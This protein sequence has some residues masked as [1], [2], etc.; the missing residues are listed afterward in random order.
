MPGNI[1]D[2]AATSS[3]K[4]ENIFDAAATSS[5]KS[6]NMFDDVAGSVKSVA[7]KA[8]HVAGDVLDFQRAK[9]QEMIFHGGSSDE[10]RRRL[11][12]KIGIEHDYEDPKFLGVQVPEWATHLGRG[13]TDTALDTVTDPLTYETM[14]GSLIAKGAKGLAGLGGRAIDAATKAPFVGDKVAAARSGAGALY[15]AAHDY[16][17][18]AGAATRAHGQ[19]A[20]DFAMGADAKTAARSDELDRRL[21]KSYDAIRSN[22]ND[23]E[24]AEALQIRNGERQARSNEGRLLV[25]PK[26]EAAAAALKQLTKSAYAL[27]ADESGQRRIANYVGT[28]RPATAKTIITKRAPAPTEADTSTLEGLADSFRADT[29]KYLTARSSA[30]VNLPRPGSA[31]STRAGQTLT[32]EDA[33]DAWDDYVKTPAVAKAYAAMSP[34]A[35]LAARTNYIRSAIAS[36]GAGTKLDPDR[37]LATGGRAIIDK[38]ERKRRLIARAASTPFEI[39]PELREFAGQPGTLGAKQYRRDYVAGPREAAEVD[40]DKEAGSFNRMDPFDPNAEQREQITIDPKQHE[41]YD[42]AM[43]GSLANTAKQVGASELRKELKDRF[44]GAVPQEIDD[45]FKVSTRATGEART[46]ADKA[47]DVWRGVISL[48]KAAIVGLSPRHMFNIANLLSAHSL[49]AIP[50]AVVTAAMLMKDPEQRYEILRKGIELGAI[51]GKSA[52]HDVPL[53]DLIARAPGVLAPIGKKI[54]GGI[55]N[56]NRATWAFDDAAAQALAKRHEA[57]GMTG[58]SAGRSARKDLVDYNNVSKF[59]E[60]A[61]NVMPFAT[62]NTSIPGAVGGALLRNPA[63]IEATNRATGGAYLGDHPEIGGHQISL[64][65]PTAEIGAGD[66]TGFTRKSLADPVKGVLDLFGL[67]AEGKKHF[68]TYGQDLHDPKKFAEFLLSMGVSPIPG[69]QEALSTL[70]LSAFKP[71]NFA[72]GIMQNSTGLDVK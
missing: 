31:P 49:S 57:A 60:Q 70:G 5:A 11:R 56:M 69:A 25:S 43:R 66:L 39:S 48:P 17:V 63:R 47:L 65:A 36:N 55:G 46:T 67:S 72:E 28:P 19:E 35:K 6:G 29:N 41:L 64:H 42:Q 45:L 54:A 26:A 52:E 15:N 24:F 27:R 30:G 40:P 13:L 53:A 22:L 68:W 7:G 10:N 34:E 51:G 33:R 20:V 12:E 23:T 2:D 9:T 18:P 1:F 14:G 58:Y 61:K 59:T 62:F 38:S 37:I 44:G 16:F 4:S 3:S 32:D 21:Q 50:E 71:R 8:F